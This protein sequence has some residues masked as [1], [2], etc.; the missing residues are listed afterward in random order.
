MN[1]TH[2][3]PYKLITS[4]FLS[5]VLIVTFSHE[6]LANNKSGSSKKAENIIGHLP[7][8][9]S[10]GAYLSLSNQFLYDENQLPV[11]TSG[12]E[13]FIPS[14]FCQTSRLEETS[15]MQME[16]SDLSDQFF[17]LIDQDNDLCLTQ[18][19]E[20][21]LAWFAL[22]PGENEWENIKAWEDLSTT[23]LD[24][25][26]YLIPPGTSQQS[27]YTHGLRIPESAIGKRIGFTYSP[28]TATGNPNIG[29][30]IKVWDIRYFFGQDK[31]DSAGYPT[32][33]NEGKR[34]EEIPL[35]T[36]LEE[37]VESP[38]RPRIENLIMKGTFLTGFQLTAEYDFIAN[39]ENEF[40]DVSRFWWGEVGTTEIQAYFQN[41]VYLSNPQSPVLTIEDVAKVYSVS[42]LP[43]KKE[44]RV[45]SGNN[46]TY[47]VVG[48]TV[49][50]TSENTNNQ[51]T[52]PSNISNLKFSNALNIENSVSATYIYEK[53]DPIAEDNSEYTWSYIDAQGVSHIL[54]SDKIIE[55]GKVPDSPKLLLEQSGLTLKLDMLPKDQFNREGKPVSISDNIET[56]EFI[57]EPTVVQL[58]LNDTNSYPVSIT[59]KY[60][61]GSD[62]ITLLGNWASTDES[63]ATVDNQGNIR[64]N[65]SLSTEAIGSITFN[66]IGKTV[67]IDVIVDALPPSIRNL[68]LISIMEN[69]E[70][71]L[72]ENQGATYDF[73]NGGKLNS[74]DRSTYIWR[75]QNETTVI[76]SGV[77][78][79]SGVVPFPS[80]SSPIYH[81]G[82]VVVLEV[83]PK[84]NF[85]RSGDMIPIEGTL[86][87][88]NGIEVEPTPLEIKRQTT[89]QLRAYAL[90][91]GGR[92]FISPIGIPALDGTWTVNGQGV[93]ISYSGY[94][95]AGNFLTSGTI[96]YRYK[97]FNIVIPYTVIE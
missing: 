6:L 9:E 88:V 41:P 90:F 62:D 80:T 96:T 21:Q 10:I 43:I 20:S 61:S 87:E 64:L 56:A 48:N 8:M 95:T 27:P 54:A 13:L 77:V 38:S 93:S 69:G 47:Y 36:S 49:T 78:V 73:D 12:S 4:L 55:S 53:G 23:I 31:Y 82:K 79:N 22:D 91:D 35:N 3:T 32:Y 17:M 45:S 68:K 15:T 24:N 85:N 29:Y 65:P 33:V 46:S 52:Q 1:S 42:V 30:P 58:T 86:E 75:I 50:T 72:F 97:N 5:I 63:I 40:E 94:V 7:Y 14:I 44:S 92:K 89:A 11:L 19:H 18:N 16:A 51:F 25:N 83:T 59:A 67:T 81:S 66:Y 26:I 84:D 34:L 74:N 57:A 39:S 28:I 37:V 2:N 70:L 71:S 76:G 60:T